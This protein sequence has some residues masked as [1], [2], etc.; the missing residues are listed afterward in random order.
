[1]SA[2]GAS[3]PTLPSVPCTGRPALAR[4][5][6][7]SFDRARG[8]HVLLEPET[9]VVLNPTGADVLGL[10]DGVRTVAEIAEEL[11]ARYDR[12]AAVIA[13]EVTAFLAQLVARRRVVIAD[14]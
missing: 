11:T 10:C 12:D 9:V 4:H 1:M 5:V 6:R 13:E 3:G 2:P 8:R 14:G 7:L